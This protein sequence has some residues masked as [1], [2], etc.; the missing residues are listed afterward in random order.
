M[1]PNSSP[2]TVNIVGMPKTI[3]VSLT[4][5][6]PHYA[7]PQ[8]QYSHLILICDAE[9]PPSAADPLAP[10]LSL[11]GATGAATTDEADDAPPAPSVRKTEPF[12][13]STRPRLA[14]HFGIILPLP[15]SKSVSSIPEGSPY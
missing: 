15:A 1:F 14:L 5:T 7:Y 13:L 11:S 10:R 8:I 9:A 2:A 3:L 12:V 6:P 4:S